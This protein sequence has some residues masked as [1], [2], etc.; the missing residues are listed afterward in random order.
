MFQANVR[1]ALL[2][3]IAVA[4]TTRTEESLSD[5]PA[6]WDREIALTTLTD[7]NP[8]PRIVEVDLEARVAEVE[9]LPGKKTKLWTYN[10]VLSGPLLR[11]NVGDT[12]IVHFKNKLPEPTTIHW[13]G[14]RVPSNMDGAGMVKVPPDGS[15]EYRFTLLDAGTFWYHPHIRS[16]AQVGY[17]LYGPLIVDD[18]SAPKL[19]SEATMILSDISIDDDGTLLESTVG[20]PIAD[21]FGREGGHMLVNGRKHPTIH[22]RPGASIRMRMINASRARYYRMALDG[23]TFTVIGSDGGLRETPFEAA[24]V[25]IVPGER[26]E[27]VVVPQK[28]GTLK[29]LPFE[30]GFGTAF[31]R[32]P[33]PILEL[34]VDDIPKTTPTPI[35]ARFRTIAPVETS[36]AMVQRIE[37]TQMTDAAKTTTLGINGQSFNSTITAKV[38]ET[39]IYEVVNTTEAH[40]P[41][42]LHGFFFQELGPDNKPITAQWK[43]TLNVPM[44]ESRRVIVKYDDRPGMWMF[45]CHILDHA[46]LGMMGMLNLSGLSGDATAA[47]HTP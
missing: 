31:A 12:V 36:G 23:H 2:L 7:R 8:D 27:V 34:D 15:F 30:R 35:P 10:G 44:K 28:S 42:H 14:V 40:H 19:G 21:L 13:H 3:V 26:I 33:E 11:A 6:D 16:A 32:V 25:M 20:G 43:D 24:E 47:N 4:C 45:H 29:W 37:L 22:A 18:P 46:D 41:F 38:G 9:V 5:P 1:R 39:N 17:G